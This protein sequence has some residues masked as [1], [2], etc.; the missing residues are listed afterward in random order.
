[1]KKLNKFIYISALCGIMLFTSGCEDFLDKGPLTEFT[2]E[3]YWTSESNVRTFAWQFYNE[4]IG[5]GNGTGT[6]AEFY[7][8]SASASNA[9][10]ISDDLCNSSYLN[11]QATASSTN[12]DWNSY[13]TSIRRSN[14]L[15]SR[16]PTVTALSQ[17]AKL[18]WE[19]VARFFRA[20][21][22]YR[23]VQRFGDVPYIDNFVGATESD[24][25]YIARMNRNMVMDKVYDDLDFVV[26]NIRVSDGVNTLNRYVAFALQSRI[27]LYE[28]T[29]RKYHNLGDGTKF[30]T[31]AKTAATE[32]MNN[33]NYKLDADYQSI[34]NSIELKNSKE[35]LLYKD[36]Q[37]SILMH[38]IQ[39]YTN[40][41]SIINGL[42]RAAIENYA[43]VDGLPITQ[44]PLYLGD[45][46]IANVLSSRD[47][48][49]AATIA[50]KYG[51]SGKEDGGLAASTGYRLILYNNPG[52]SGTQV[53]TGGQNHIDTPIFGL[54]EVYLNYAE[55]CAEL[56]AITQADLD[57]SINK[58]RL[59]AGIAPLSYLSNDN[60]QV[61]GLSINDPARTNTLEQI[62]GVVSSVIWEIRRERRAEFMSWTHI[63][64]FDLMRWKK[65]EYLDMNL[66]PKVGQGAK[67]GA[68]NKGKT[69]VDT[70]GYILPF[71][72][73]KRVFTNPK[74]YLNSIPTGEKSLYD[75][76][77]VVLLQNPGW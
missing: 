41:S 63:R 53:T 3:N 25:I 51:Y 17:E 66:N 13:Y 9:M 42:S 48:R 16:I 49:L 74:N 40:T 22:Y 69:T 71:A 2:D 11:F 36:Y 54:A 37:P 4:F 24:K 15:I 8:Q 57:K 18:H 19:A 64:L 46:Q 30:L 23:L 6:T 76:E 68:A 33:A 44:S 59:R 47:K 29:Y 72:A 65:G 45:D 12:S 60:V 31:S 1:M 77:G 58:L 38:S 75:A 14:L 67:V 28:G 62:S 7:F 10:I 56:N 26:K 55:A 43:C 27:C 35:M 34:Y 39:S 73:N 20:F 52:L 50:S 70:D 61:G 5:Y 21:N 32:I